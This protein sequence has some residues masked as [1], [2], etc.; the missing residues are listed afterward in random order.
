PGSKQGHSPPKLW[1]AALLSRPM[2]LPL[3]Q[4]GMTRVLPSTVAESKGVDY[5][6]WTGNYLQNV[7]SIG[8]AGYDIVE[9]GGTDIRISNTTMHHRI[10][11]KI[12][13]GKVLSVQLDHDR[14]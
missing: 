5:E 11:A 1:R 2:R 7:P 13:F 12:R 3:P 6:P 14:A 9:P 10:T 8:L 4:R